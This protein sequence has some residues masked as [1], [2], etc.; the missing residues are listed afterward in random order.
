MSINSFPSAGAQNVLLA[1]KHLNASQ[2]SALF[3]E[4]NAGTFLQLI[5]GVSGKVVI[6]L[7]I[8]SRCASGTPWVIAGG[9]QAWNVGLHTDPGAGFFGQA[10][11]SCLISPAGSVA[12]WG[13]TVMTQ[14]SSVNQNLYIGADLEIFVP[15]I[16]NINT[17][18]PGSREIDF[19]ILYYLL[20]VS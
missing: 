7:F 19:T 17:V 9:S 3:A 11:N 6:P 5:P 4:P 10:D 12:S 15:S 16:V 1:T 14:F 8:F 13:D 20:S 18:T 2:I